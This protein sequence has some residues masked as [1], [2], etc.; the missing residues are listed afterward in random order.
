MT[1]T[2]WFARGLLA[3]AVT[4]GACVKQAPD[5]GFAITGASETGGS[6]DGSGSAG[7]GFTSAAPHTTLA[8]DSDS[9][10][11]GEC[12]LGRT[13]LDPVPEGWF[14]PAAIA[15]T[16]MDAPLPVCPP[17]FPK[18]GLSVLE[19]YHDPGPAVCDCACTID[20]ASS[21]VAYGYSHSDGACS[22]YTQ[23][24]QFDSDP[25]EAFS[26]TASTNLYMY[27]Q[28]QGFC[29]P[30][31]TQ[32]LPEVAWDAQITSCKPNDADLSGSC[33]DGGVCGP[34]T[35]EGFDTICIYAE[36][37]LAC[38]AGAYAVEHD[39]VSGADD[40]R[41]C[42]S[43]A[44]GTATATCAGTMLVYDAADCGGSQI[45][46][47]PSDGTCTPVN[48]GVSAALQYTGDDACPVTTA[49]MPMGTIAPSGPFTFC[50]TE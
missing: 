33:G 27:Q 43:C 46:S 32:E 48:A 3:S 8:P 38:P 25:C 29:Q 13:C 47:V 23:F 6:I 26:I 11:V 7:T 28:G 24:L 40:Q 17:S 10:D 20:L 16:S 19:G 15:R 21:C 35:P 2:H 14:G 44:C 5:D 42:S 30:T 12:G 41:G 4:A 36:G 45:A 1:R 50:C 22:T 39:F 9:G 49:P 37:D 18:A 31:K 34:A